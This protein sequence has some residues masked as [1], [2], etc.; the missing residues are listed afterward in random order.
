MKTT[1]QEAFGHS[2]GIKSL[3][4]EIK[5]SFTD[6]IIHPRLSDEQRTGLA[7]LLRELSAIVF[8]TSPSRHEGVVV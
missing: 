3:L 6:L 7:L 5:N 2:P 8:E 4:T 1:Y